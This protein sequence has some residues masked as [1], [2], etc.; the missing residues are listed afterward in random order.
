MIEPHI[1]FSA[2]GPLVLLGWAALLVSLFVPAIRDRV[3]LVTGWLIPGAIGL[4]YVAL[5]AAGIGNVGGTDFGSIPEIRRVF[6]DDSALAA[7]WFHYLAFDMF[8]GT[9]LARDGLEKGVPALLLVP[10]L[11]LT[12]LF[13]PAGLLLY[14]V[15]RLAVPTK[16]QPVEMPA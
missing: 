9:M 1:A 6:A 15:V 12:F 10:P 4:A 2:A 5:I 7:G 14:L 11:I 13:G 16:R 3:W 8:V